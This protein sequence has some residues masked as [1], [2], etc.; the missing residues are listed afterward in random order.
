M[1]DNIPILNE[2]GAS[3][4]DCWKCIYFKVSWDPT[5]PYAC[6][7]MGF[8]SRMLPSIEV[9]LADGNE[10]RGFQSK[11]SSHL[12]IQQAKTSDNTRPLPQRKRVSS[13]QVWE[14]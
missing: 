8:K 13:T 12:L 6:R 11:P 10:C 9:R 14:A 1:P 2:V 5:K 4:P 7:M 3:R